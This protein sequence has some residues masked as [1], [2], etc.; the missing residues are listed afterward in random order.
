MISASRMNAPAHMIVCAAPPMSAPV[1]RSAVDGRVALTID[2]T[3]CRRSAVSSPA[4]A[5]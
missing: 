4:A 5:M 3:T 1:T 2:L